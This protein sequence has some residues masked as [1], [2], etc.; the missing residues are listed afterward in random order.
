[1]SDADLT[2]VDAWQLGHVPQLFCASVDAMDDAM[3]RVTTI[4]LAGILLSMVI[5]TLVIW[6]LVG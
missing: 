5:I 3:D 4:G 1:L 6:S 2:P